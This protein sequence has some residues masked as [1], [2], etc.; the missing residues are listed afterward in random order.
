[1]LRRHGPSVVW[2]CKAQMLPQGG[3]FIFSFEQASGLKNGND[4]FAEE[5]K[6]MRVCNADIKAVCRV[7][8]E[9]ALDLACN[10]FW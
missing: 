7:T 5:C 8:E 4:A 2:N 3:A 9:P 10:R 1:M 6:I